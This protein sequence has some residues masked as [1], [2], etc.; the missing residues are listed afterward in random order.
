M[1][2]RAGHAI[3]DILFPPRCVGCR[4]LLK[5]FV[6][7]PEI[8]C[9]TCLRMWNRARAEAAETAAEAAAAGHAYL[10]FYRGGKTDGVP[11]RFIYHLKH[12]GDR[13]AFSFA[14]STLSYAVYMALRSADCA[15]GSTRPIVTYPPRRRSAV[16]R[17]GF[18]QGKRLAKAI[19]GAVGGEF[20]SLLR[21][22]YRASSEQKT[23]NAEARAEN[24]SRAY[25][26]RS[27]TAVR[28]RVV[29]LCDDLATTGATLAA[30]ETLLLDA[31]AAA[32]VWATV[33]YT[34]A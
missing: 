24:A 29:I 11:E 19:S 27:G 30:C 20:A 10:T 21:R 6:S 28:G 4:E 18:D 25:T 7:P 9:P 26:L 31:G 12:T 23:L 32:V 3:R 34:T 16:N 8:F 1:A 15:Q 33:A 14:A 13:R 22:T 5:P 17:D 2:C